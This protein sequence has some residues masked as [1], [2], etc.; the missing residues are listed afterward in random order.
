M[1]RRLNPE[2]QCPETDD[3][4]VADEVENGQRFESAHTG[5]NE[6]RSVAE[7]V[8][9]DHPVVVSMTAPVMTG[10]AIME[11]QPQRARGLLRAIIGG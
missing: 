4:A 6:P 9:V 7:D 3:L 2:F 11:N 1:G 10:P 8:Q 5:F